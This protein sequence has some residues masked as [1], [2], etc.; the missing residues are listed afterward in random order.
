ME[1]VYEFSV[2][3]PDGTEQSLS[4][5]EGKPLLIVNTA[6]KCGFVKQFDELQEVYE[7]YKDQGLTVLGF[8]SD[9][10]NNQEF[11]SSDEAEEFCR[12]NFGVSFPMF[13]K[14][15]VKGDRAEPLFQYL[16]S[17]KKGMLT[18]G[19]KWNF[20]KFLVDR[21]GNVVDRFAPQT[22]PLKMKDAIEKLI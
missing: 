2:Q 13:A 11:D 7:T 17:Q 9:N 10:F 14:V 15:D 5:F 18:E 12:M 4:E 21:Q 16:A 1:S 19:I 3:K 20:T 22:G 6:S 8:P